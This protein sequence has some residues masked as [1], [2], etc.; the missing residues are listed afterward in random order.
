MLFIEASTCVFKYILL[1]LSAE[2][3]LVVFKGPVLPKGSKTLSSMRAQLDID[4]EVAAG[5][6]SYYPGNV[7]AS[8]SHIY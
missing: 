4:L 2:V 3:E 1:Y 6:A 8:K 7:L 5:D